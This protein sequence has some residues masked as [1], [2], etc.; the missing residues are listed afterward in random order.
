M[1]IKS[2]DWSD[3]KE[4]DVCV[5]FHSFVLHV[6]GGPPSTFVF[7]VFF[8][9]IW[10][11]LSLLFFFSFCFL[12]CNHCNNKGSCDP[13]RQWKGST[14]NAKMYVLFF[15]FFRLLV[16]CHRGNM[17]GK[18]WLK[19]RKKGN[20]YKEE[21]RHPSTRDSNHHW[22]LLSFHSAVNNSSK[23]TKGKQICK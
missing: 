20:N 6:G 4:Q 19:I 15:F 5:S 21:K 8:F 14:G 22:S 7:T 2:P 18:T 23:E 3:D 13:A 11:L 17:S 12:L 10:S 16:C 1:L 9:S